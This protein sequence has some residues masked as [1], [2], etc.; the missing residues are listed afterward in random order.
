MLVVTT[1]ATASSV[2]SVKFF[3]R[4]SSDN[5]SW[6]AW[7]Q[8][9]AAAT[10]VPYSESFSFSNGAGYYEFYSVASDNLGTTEATPAFAQ[11][12]VH[13]KAATGA[14]QSI[15]F[16]QPADV[17]TG[18]AFSVS[19]S[20]SSTL[21][22][23]ISS[24]TLSNCTVSGNIVTS[25]APGICTLAASQAGDNGY[26]LPAG[27]IR[28]LA[29]NALVQQITFNTL[30]DQ[31]LGAGTVTLSATASSALPVLFT[32]RTAGI[33]SVAGNT[34]TLLAAGQCTIAANQ[35]GGGNY[36]VAPT[37]TQTFSVSTAVAGNDSGDVPL[38]GWAMIL[39][40]GGLLEGLRRQ[41]L[42]RNQRQA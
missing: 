11:A 12:S 41:S 39:L 42:K 27:T 10:T 19:A 7:T 16:A 23:T 5:I 37:V 28:S 6:G 1:Q 29:V 22:V 38:P 30:S 17:Q 3:Y 26:W 18:S 33:C 21:P 31:L 34:V 15:T 14:V 20:A 8:T 2:A 40:A 25:L 13:Y 32:S 9:G 36:A 35:T 4:Y 24:Q